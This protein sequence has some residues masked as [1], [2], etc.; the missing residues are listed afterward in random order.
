VLKAVAASDVQWLL[1]FQLACICQ[2][3]QQKQ[4]Q[5]QQPSE[6]LF[7]GRGLPAGVQCSM[8][9]KINDGR[10][11]V[12]VLVSVLAFQLDAS[13]R[14]RQNVPVGRMTTADT[15]ATEVFAPNAAA[16]VVATAAEA[17]SAS[18]QELQQQQQRGQQQ[19]QQERQGT[20]EQQQQR[21]GKQEQQDQQQQQQQ[22]QEKQHQ[23]QQ[24]Q[25]QQRQEKQDQQQQQQQWLRL[26]LEAPCDLP[27]L[28]PHEFCFLPPLLV[29]PLVLTLLQLCSELKPM[30]SVIV[31]TLS[32][33]NE[34][35]SACLRC[36]E[37]LTRASTVGHATA[38]ALPDGTMALVFDPAS[39]EPQPAAVEMQR[40]YQQA[41][42]AMAQ[43]LL[44][45]MAQPLL[46][47]V[48]PVAV[49]AVRQ[50]EQ[51]L[52]RGVVSSS[53][54]VTPGQT[55]EQQ[56][57]AIADDVL[58]KFGRLVLRVMSVGE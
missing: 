25:Q 21:Q 28:E 13:I 47:A 6:H 40:A 14:V 2:Q 11:Y 19:G 16:A 23:Q 52:S 50:M 8:Y 57:A 45:A 29:Q 15:L 7:A 51:G 27:V 54:R 43:P 39:R 10:D 41:L 34:L 44:H 46:H 4:Q 24:Q 18:T 35:M 30:L 5:Q 9:F 38:V 56:A 33:V 48:G 1:C 22:R 49:R 31:R 55:A 3:L 42:H 32:L 20:Q 58:N 17:A 53:I 36:S 26:S 12:E 37:L